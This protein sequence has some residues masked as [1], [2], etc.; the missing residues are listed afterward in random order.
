VVV[1]VVVKVAE[2]ATVNVVGETGAVG[3]IVVVVVIVDVG[4][5]IV[6]V[7][8]VV[9]VTEAKVKKGEVVVAA[10]DVG[11][12]LGEPEV[13]RMHAPLLLPKKLLLL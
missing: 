3:E 4:G 13:L 10:E 1:V 9:S 12:V 11:K 2:I 5:V 7:R 6:E 8:V